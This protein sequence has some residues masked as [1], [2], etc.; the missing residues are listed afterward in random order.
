MVRSLFRSAVG[1]AVELVRDGEVKHK[2]YSACLITLADRWVVVTAGHAI[3]EV[4]DAI[5]AGYTLRQCMYI[6]GGRAGGFHFD[7]RRATPWF[8]YEE[9]DLDYGGLVVDDLSRRN[10]EAAGKRPFAEEGLRE[11]IGLDQFPIL[12]VYGFPELRSDLTADYVSAESFMVAL[13]KLDERPEH[14]FY[15]PRTP[16]IFASAAGTERLG[17][18]SGGPVYGLRQWEGRW[19]YHTLG[20]QVSANHD[21]RIVRVVLIQAILDELESGLGLRRARAEP[22]G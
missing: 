11:S 14:V 13:T 9:P 12:A 15:E 21:N 16:T 5:A 4:E 7:W 19:V 18:L 8:R 3:K 1:I 22:A 20:I 10:F 2:L 17:G 6:D